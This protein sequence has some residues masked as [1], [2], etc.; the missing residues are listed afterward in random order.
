MNKTLGAVGVTLLVVVGCGNTVEVT[1]DGQGGA[2][3]FNPV[4]SSSTSKATTTTSVSSASVQPKPTI[5]CTDV[6]AC[7]GDA[8]PNCVTTC[9]KSLDD[10]KAQAASSG[11]SATYGALFDCAA[12]NAKCDAAAKSYVVPQGVCDAQTSAFTSCINSSSTGV[13][14]GVGPSSGVTT[15]SG[16]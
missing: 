4:T 13:T 16:I 2:S 6:C 15:G 3:P 7:A 8:T 5:D 10:G 1:G 11:C 9:Q 12:L 14:T